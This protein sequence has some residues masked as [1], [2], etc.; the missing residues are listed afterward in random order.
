M[1]LSQYDPL[2]ERIDAG[3]GSLEDAGPTAA[4]SQAFTRA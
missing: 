1:T 4:E 2:P 3:T